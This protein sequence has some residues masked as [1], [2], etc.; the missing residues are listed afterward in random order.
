MI[1]LIRMILICSKY[2]NNKS[3]KERN[4]KGTGKKSLPPK[5]IEKDIRE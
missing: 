5:Y 4:A 3:P 1:N 2:E